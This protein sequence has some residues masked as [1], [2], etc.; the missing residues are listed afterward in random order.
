MAF[1]Y[2]F[3]DQHTLDQIANH[4]IPTLAGRHSI[5]IWDAGCAMGPEPYS[6]AITF[7]EHLGHFAFQNLRIDASDIDESN[8]FER[9]ITNG[10]YTEEE[11]GRI[12]AGIMQKYFSPANDPHRFRVSGDIR[13]RVSFRRHDLLSLVPFGSDYS[14]VVC[15]N[16]LLHFQPPQRLEVM[17]MFHRVL[18]PGGFLVTEQTQRLP[19][20][21]SQ[22]FDR[23]TPE[24]QLFRKIEVHRACHD[25]DAR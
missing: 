11:L 10:I 12:P 8:L 3:R 21:A 13:Q 16:V 4:V 14:L 6:L 23:V 15:K 24:A 19:A 17:R 5:R 18:L 9:I 1:S 2:F 22:F 7:A 20:E 25:T